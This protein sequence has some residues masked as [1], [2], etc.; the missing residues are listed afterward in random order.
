[1]DTPGKLLLYGGTFDPPHMG[2]M[3][4]LRAVMK[5][6]DP[7]KVLKVET[8]L[9]SFHQQPGN[10]SL[11]AAL[12]RCIISIGIAACP[13]TFPLCPLG[14][15]SIPAGFFFSVTHSLSPPLAD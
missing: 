9:R 11:T 10:G 13:V 1:M 3:N 14:C 5:A 8:V 2:H 12:F 6:V 7:D 15:C 4:N